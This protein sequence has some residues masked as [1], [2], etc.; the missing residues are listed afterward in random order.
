MRRATKLALLFAVS[1]PALFVLWVLFVGTFAGPEMLV[2]AGA[3]LVAAFALC[4]VQQ[5][6]PTHFRPRLSDVAQL[7][8]VP[9]LLLSDTVVIL[10]VSISDLFGGRKASSAFRVVTFRAGTPG[11]ARSTGRRVL[12]VAGSTVSPNCIVLGVNANQNELLF[13]QI[14]KTPLPT[15]IKNLG[16][17]A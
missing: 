9:W 12:A 2:G 10:L 13:H 6:E 7:I 4:I 11:G 15:M 5:A 16:A 1:A 17:D 14:K 8:Y 3:A